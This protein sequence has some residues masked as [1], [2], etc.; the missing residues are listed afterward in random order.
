MTRDSI[1]T[2]LSFLLILFFLTGINLG[3][4]LVIAVMLGVSIF[5]R[6]IGL[7]F[8]QF[9][10]NKRT[11][12]LL[13]IILIT[14]ISIA[15]SPSFEK[16]IKQAE[17]RSPYLL[18][19]I[20]FGLIPMPTPKK[21]LIIKF[22]ITMVA[23][24]PIIGFIDNIFIYQKTNDTGYFYNDNLIHLFH[25]QAVYYGI[26]INLSIAS[27]FYL[28]FNDKL[29]SKIE[30]NMSYIFLLL[31]I[32][33]QYLLASR[34][35]IAMTLILIIFYIILIGIK[36]IGKPKAIISLVGFIIIISLLT[37]AFPKALN[38]FKS[39]TNIKYNFENK[40][41]I[42][43][44]NGET[45]D[46]NWNSLNTRI[47]IWK[48][49]WDEIKK[50]PVIGYGIG[51]ANEQL[52]RGYHEKKFHFAI[53]QNY[54]SHNQYLDMLLTSGAIGLLALLIFTGGILWYGLKDK[55]WLLIGFVAIFIISCLTENILSK[56]QG[57][58]VFS[59]F[60]S[61]IIYSRNL[62]ADDEANY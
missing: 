40:N 32:V 48:C 43:H 62:I 1:L 51:D 3:V 17:M 31:L 6:N 38:R 4:N 39:I 15:I 10:S 60:F 54:N 36:K 13:S 14:L 49:A 11:W 55:D 19:P 28:W 59:L 53:K 47:A 30:K 56:N 2:Y 16:A 61:L 23:F 57:I 26:F 21:D 27:L 22:F 45:K 42:N 33:T 5:Q 8:K 34:I 50:K 25:R 46:E 41:S 9:F 58:V 7:K 37:I 12:I 35:A 18:F 20:I 44:F 24:L 29:K 52:V